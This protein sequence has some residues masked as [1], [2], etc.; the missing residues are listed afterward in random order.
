MFTRNLILG[1]V[2]ALCLSGCAVRIAESSILVS[3]AS[4]PL[5]QAVL[6]ARAPG[7]GFEPQTIVAPDG[8]RLSGVLLRRPG[9]SLT[10]LYFG[11]NTFRVGQNGAALAAR[12]APADA[13]LMVVDHRGSGMSGGTP[14]IATLQGDALAVFDHLAAQ[15]GISASRIMIHGH[16]LGSFMAGD[17]A[18]QRDTA[19]V[20]LESSATTTEAWVRAALP[21][22]ARLVMRVDIEESLRGQGNLA[23]MSQIQEPLL[24]L[25]G[26]RDDTTPPSLSRAL[27]AAAPGGLYRKHL[28]IVPD[29]GHNDVLR[30]DDGMNAYLAFIRSL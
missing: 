25:V 17:V 13:N 29:A 14:S 3:G 21:A 26:A 2:A 5:E 19:G 8:V 28:T 4:P 27:Y 23:N 9:A 16:S 20:V 11:G 12:L 1:V 7:Y 15:P 22:A 10:I 30:H 6:E 24:V 18:A